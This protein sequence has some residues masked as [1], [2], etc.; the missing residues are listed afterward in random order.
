MNEDV[1]DSNDN[2]AHEI[3]A[4]HGPYKG[5]LRIVTVGKE[6][7]E[8]NPIIAIKVLPFSNYIRE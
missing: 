4:K 8:T 2:E 6:F 3:E 7:E 5:C 1:R